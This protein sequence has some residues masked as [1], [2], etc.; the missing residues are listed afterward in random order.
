MVVK[1]IKESE[2]SKNKGEK[3]LSVQSHNVIASVWNN[4]SKTDDKKQY[5]SIGL[6]IGFKKKDAT[7][8]ENKSITL[9]MNELD[10][11]ISVLSEIKRQDLVI[12]E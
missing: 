7:E 10:A 3:I 8:Y 5:Q 12:T 6:S 4:V 9:F 1:P 11:V 2:V